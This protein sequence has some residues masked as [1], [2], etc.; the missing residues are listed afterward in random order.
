MEE[1]ALLQATEEVCRLM[2]EQGVSRSELA[3]RLGISASEVTQ[4]LD[5]TRNLT[6]RSLVGMLHALGH[7][8]DLRAVSAVRDQDKQHDNPTQRQVLHG[9]NGD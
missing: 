4:R 6:I 1:K 8:L 9:R 5:G 7:G 3:R 2:D